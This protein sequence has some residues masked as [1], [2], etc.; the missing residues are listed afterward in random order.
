MSIIRL[1][2]RL[3]CS[4]ISKKSVSKYLTTSALSTT[5]YAY[6][7]DGEAT[8]RWQEQQGSDE[9]SRW[10]G[11]YHESSLPGLIPCLYS[12]VERNSGFDWRGAA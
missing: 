4:L 10:Q 1:S 12:S 2:R 3:R 5:I 8:G 6:H 7:M 11:E 9:S